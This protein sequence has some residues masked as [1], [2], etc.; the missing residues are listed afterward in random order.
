M[1][2]IIDGES[3][4]EIYVESDRVILKQNSD[5]GVQ[6]ISLQ[7][8]QVEKLINWFDGYIEMTRESLAEE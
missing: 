4:I 6:T 1:S 7:L 3:P 5:E 2:G 8:G